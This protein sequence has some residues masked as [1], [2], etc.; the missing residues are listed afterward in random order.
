MFSF[1]GKN[2]AKTAAKCSARCVPG[3]NTVLI[4]ADVATAAWAIY[5]VAKNVSNEANSYRRG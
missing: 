1:F 2:A 4:A 3:L 5:Q